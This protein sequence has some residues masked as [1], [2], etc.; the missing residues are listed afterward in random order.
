MSKV[1]ILLMPTPAAIA[2][3]QLLLSFPDSP[4]FV[5][6]PAACKFIGIARQ[7]GDHWLAQGKFPVP[8]VRLGTR[9]LGVPMAGLQIWLE[10]ALEGAGVGLAA[11]TEAPATCNPVQ[12]VLG[13]VSKKRG[14]G[15]PRKTA[16]A[17]K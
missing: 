2:A 15:R 17:S 11:V 14:R 8:T 10:A 4:A 13:I 6:F 3:R 16:G 5:P 12:A 1:L 7:T 9:K